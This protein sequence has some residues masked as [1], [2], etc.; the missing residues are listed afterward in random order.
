MPAVET[1]RGHVKPAMCD[2]LG[3]MNVG[4]YTEICG[5]GIFY[6]QG[7]L[8][9]D[10]TEAAAGRGPAFAVVHADAQFL[11]EVRVGE[12]LRLETGVIEIGTKSCTF[13]KRIFAGNSG[14]LAFACRFRSALL[15]LAT[16]RAIPI[17]PD[18][19]AGLEQ[20]RVPDP[21]RKASRPARRS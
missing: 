13:D 11:R 7:L 12:V 16:R 17:P 5:D 19:R 6:L 1:F 20:Y 2:H 18:M 9:L 10:P 8:G 15:D 21:E 14:E 3:H 4:R